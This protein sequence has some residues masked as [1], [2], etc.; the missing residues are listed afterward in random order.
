MITKKLWI[1]LAIPL[2]WHCKGENKDAKAETNTDSDAKV[3]HFKGRE[4]DLTPFVEGFPYSQFMPVYAAEKLYYMERGETTDLLEIDLEGHPD[5]G[6]GRKISDIDYATRNVWNIRYNENDKQLYWT[7]DEINDEI[8]NLTRLNPENGAVEKLTD[9][10]YIFG[11]RWNEAKDQV[12]YVA[13]LGDKEDRLGELRVMDLKT[14]NE[15]VIGQ[16]SPEMR[17]TWG[18]PS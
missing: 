15:G 8:I 16:D 2:L 11:Y 1:F 7:G 3:V 6:Q 5:L 12:A 13:R 17:F 14:L 9:V 10:P 18:S 4:I